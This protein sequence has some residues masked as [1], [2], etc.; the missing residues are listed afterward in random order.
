MV[1]YSIFSALMVA[2]ALAALFALT[3]CGE[4]P[5]GGRYVSP[6]VS[7]VCDAGRAVYSSHDKGGVAV[8]PNAPECRK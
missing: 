7:K 8:V 4:R 2:A 5:K 3:A 1:R 6:G